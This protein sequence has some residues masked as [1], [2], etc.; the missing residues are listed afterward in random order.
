MNIVNVHCGDSSAE[1]LRRSG[2][3][4]PGEHIVWTEVLHDG[5]LPCDDFHS[6]TW[7]DT[8]AG[9]LFGKIGGAIPKDKIIKKLKTQDGQ[10]EDALKKAD[11]T[12]FWFD[13][14]MFD[15][16]TL[17]RH[18]KYIS[19]HRK[20]VNSRLTLISAGSFPGFRKFRG[21]GELDA[22]QLAS[23][24]PSKTEITEE[25]VSLGAMAWDSL[26][27]DDPNNIFACSKNRDLKLKLPFI[28]NA[29]YRYIEQFPSE[30]NGL[31]RLESEILLSLADH[32]YST[33]L[34]L[35]SLISE[36]EE[37]PYFGDTTVWQTLNRMAFC[38]EP[39]IRYSADTPL[40]LWG[41]PDKSVIEQTLRV[42][43]AGVNVM[44][45][46]ADN[47]HLNGAAFILGKT[48]FSGRTCMRWNGALGRFT[49]K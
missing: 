25:I 2:E 26:L 47:I 4:V 37:P 14:C 39:L 11:E 6:E 49:Y 31:S 20:D 41:E 5:S 44:H 9:F 35:F 22:S 48:T 12:L 36:M 10:L 21:L 30:T 34:K 18:L 15:Q 42:T 24:M 32:P 19:G 7:Y 13:A 17:A 33:P 27:S 23:L 46:K 38:K 29:L 8:R 1:I 16:V 28:S 45:N 43:A 40:P 3:S